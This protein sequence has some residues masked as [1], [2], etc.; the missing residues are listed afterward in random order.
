MLYNLGAEHFD[1]DFGT[2]YLLFIV[3]I[4]TVSTIIYHRSKSVLA[5]TTYSAIIG[6]WLLNLAH[7]L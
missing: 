4:G 3:V 6:V 2:M 7:H 1:V 5:S